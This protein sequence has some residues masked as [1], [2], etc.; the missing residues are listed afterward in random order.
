[1]GLLHGRAWAGDTG[2]LGKGLAVL[3]LPPQV[4]GSLPSAC[5]LPHE[6][7]GCTLGSLLLCKNDRLRSASA[8]SSQLALA[9][10]VG[11]LGGGN[12]NNNNNKKGLKVK[13]KDVRRCIWMKVPVLDMHVFERCDTYSRHL[14]VRCEVPDH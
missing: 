13:L 6:V 7:T 10:C 9:S 5:V 2:R 14:S 3:H 1:M 8:R 12:K 4:I 11:G